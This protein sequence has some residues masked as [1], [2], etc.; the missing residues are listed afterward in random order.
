M[1]LKMKLAALAAG[2]TMMAA[3]SAGA[4][5]LLVHASGVASG[6]DETGDLLGVI[7]ATYSDVAFS[8]D[9]TID[10]SKGARFTGPFGPL[11]IDVLQGAGASNPGDFTETIDGKMIAG[12]YHSVFLMS[13]DPSNGLSQFR[14]DFTTAG[15][16]FAGFLVQRPDATFLTYETIPGGNLCVGATTCRWDFADGIHTIEAS[17]DTFTVTAAAV[18]EPASWA[19]M[20]GGFG[21]VGAVLRQRRAVAA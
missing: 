8:L 14:A 1:R 18:P 2:A 15:G 6:Y 9:V 10:L 11:S 4:T 7:G 17:L 16:L 13:L 19:L 12:A 21:L 20:I 5:V 3:G